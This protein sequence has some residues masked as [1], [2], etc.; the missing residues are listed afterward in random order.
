MNCYN[1]SDMVRGWFI[2]PFSP[3]LLDTSD[4]EC[5]VKRYVAGDSEAK[6]MH[7]IATEFTVIINGRVRMSGQEYG[8]GDIVEVRPGEATDFVAL[9]DVTTF[10]V[11]V[12]SVKNDKYEY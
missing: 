2:G 7:K 1:L 11:K 4:F 10:V 3:T 6:H 8:D 5:A 12:P 9:T